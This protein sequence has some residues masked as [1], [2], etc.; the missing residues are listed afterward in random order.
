M[1]PVSG[2]HDDLIDYLRTVLKAYLTLRPIGKIRGDPFVMRLP[3]LGNKSRE[4]DLQIILQANL[5]RLKDTYTDGPA[6]ICIE[7]VSPG[8]I[9]TDYEDKTADYEAGGV[10]AAQ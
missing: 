4:P 8:S 1:S 10:A 5:H 9:K 2:R 7:V 6:D 3:A